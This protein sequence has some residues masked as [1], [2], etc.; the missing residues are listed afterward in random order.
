MILSRRSLAHAAAAGFG[1]A[2]LVTRADTL[3]LSGTGYPVPLARLPFGAHSH[4][5]QPWFP[6][7]RTRAAAQIARGVGVMLRG[8]DASQDA[9]DMLRRCGFRPR[10]G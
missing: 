2:P 10:A 7:V 1:L 3:P 4:W 6:L 8:R 5:L 9:L